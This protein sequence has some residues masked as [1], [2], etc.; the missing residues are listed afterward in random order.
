MQRSLEMDGNLFFHSDMFR[1]LRHCIIFTI[2]LFSGLLFA[3]HAIAGDVSAIEL[4]IEQPQPRVNIPGVEYTEGADIPVETSASGQR[5]YL[6]I[7]FI[8]EFFRSIYQF[9]IGLIGLTATIMIIIS[10]AQW[11]TSAGSADRITSAKKRMLGAITGLIIAVSSYTLLY[12]IN[13]QLVTF[14]SLKILYVEEEPAPEPEI[15][16]VVYPNG[17]KMSI[18]DS[19]GNKIVIDKPGWTRETFHCP[20]AQSTPPT[21]VMPKTETDTFRCEKGM[22]DTFT[23]RKDLQDAVCKAAEN[24]HKQGYTLIVRGS[25]RSFAK[26]VELWCQD[27]LASYPDPATRNKFYAVPGYSRHGHG[28]AIDVNL[29]DEDGENLMPGTNSKSQCNVNPEYIR[30]LAKAFYDA[31]PKWN[32]LNTEVWHFEYGTASNVGKHLGYP[33]APVCP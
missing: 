31:D 18:T 20:S 6:Y 2:V 13:P 4:L 15:T 12:A 8:G 23:I 19:S 21:G 24:L 3:P 26:Q 29:G 32:R 22:E 17:G 1:L 16:H 11:I 25:Y 30:I 27:G 5:T 28:V 7:P 33:A 14:R 10:G 9:G